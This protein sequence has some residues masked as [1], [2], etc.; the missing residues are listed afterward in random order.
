MSLPDGIVHRALAPGR[1]L[2]EP[3]S[4]SGATCETRAWSRGHR[5][6]MIFSPRNHLL[7]R[8]HGDERVEFSLKTKYG[9]CSEI[10]EAADM[11]PRCSLPWKRI[12]RLIDRLPPGACPDIPT[13]TAESRRLSR[14]GA[15]AIV[16]REGSGAVA[17]ATDWLTLEVNSVNRR[18]AVTSSTPFDGQPWRLRLNDGTLPAALSTAIEGMRTGER[19]RIYAAPVQSTHVPRDVSSDVLFWDVQLIATSKAEEE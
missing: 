19:R 3:A 18:S 17:E 9:S 14:P 11:T 16:I 6:P 15:L 5:L 8:R 2:T 4:L 7:C 13:A 12:H 10:I 1:H